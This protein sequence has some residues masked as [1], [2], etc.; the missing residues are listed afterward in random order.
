VR[1]FHDSG[2]AG[3]A[4]AIELLLHCLERLRDGHEQVGCFLVETPANWW[5]LKANLN[6]CSISAN[7]SACGSWGESRRRTQRAGGMST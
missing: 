7:T 1:R 2:S 4:R 5:H 6:V 3:L